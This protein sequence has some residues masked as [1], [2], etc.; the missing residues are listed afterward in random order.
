MATTAWPERLTRSLWGLTRYVFCSACRK[1]LMRPSLI[2]HVFA[3]SFQ[4]AADELRE[5]IKQ[6]VVD[7][8]WTSCRQLLRPTES[9][10]EGD[11]TC[12]LPSPLSAHTNSVRA[13]LWRYCKEFDDFDQITFPIAYGTD[14]GEANVVEVIRIS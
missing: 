5:Q 8:T 7:P 12:P 11:A 2:F 3:K 9:L 14:V 13:Y 1:S 10:P 4:D 6:K